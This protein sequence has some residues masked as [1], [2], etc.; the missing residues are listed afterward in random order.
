MLLPLFK[1]KNG[2][3]TELTSN[4]ETLKE[5]LHCHLPQET[6]NL[7]GHLP[8]VL[9]CHLATHP[10]PKLNVGSFSAETPLCLSFCTFSL[11]VLILHFSLSAA[12]L[13]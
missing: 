4:L 8:S 9:C 2:N 6:E 3:G 11:R 7:I 12:T 13:C 1:D 5:H 10:K